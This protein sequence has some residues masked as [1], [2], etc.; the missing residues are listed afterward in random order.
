VSHFISCAPFHW[1]RGY[2]GRGSDWLQSGRPRSRSSG[3]R[4]IKNFHFSVS[5]RPSL[6]PTESPTQ[7]VR[8]VLSLGVNWPEP[9]AYHT[10]WFST[11]Y[12]PKY[13]DKFTFFN[14]FLFAL[15]MNLQH[16]WHSCRRMHKLIRKEL[17]SFSV[18]KQ[19]CS[20]APER[21]ALCASV[22]EMYILCLMGLFRRDNGRKSLKTQPV[23]KI[24]K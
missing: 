11:M 9:E 5:S 22:A 20:G 1:E 6:G 23:V 15:D 21:D 18:S 13:R 10:S 3:S 8:G 24:V 2:R 4:A 16:Y 7:W 14:P 19:L 12:L 17:L